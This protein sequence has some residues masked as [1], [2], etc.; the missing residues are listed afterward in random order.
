MLR[1]NQYIRKVLGQKPREGLVT[2]KDA[3]YV[4]SEPVVYSDTELEKFFRNANATSSSP[5]FS[6]LC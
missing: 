4:E 2:V 1:C 5:R 6:R 3:K